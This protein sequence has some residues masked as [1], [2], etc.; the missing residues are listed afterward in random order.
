MARQ[1][2]KPVAANSMSHQ[3]IAEDIAAFRKRG[4]RIE[5]IGNTPLRNRAPTPFRSNTT[6]TRKAPAERPAAAAPKRAK[7]AAAG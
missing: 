1:P 7:K 5:V 4:G 3:S 6:A 2:S